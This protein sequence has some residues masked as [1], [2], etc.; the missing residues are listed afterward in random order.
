M[1]RGPK[2]EA[3]VFEFSLLVRLPTN[4]FMVFN[5]TICCPGWALVKCDAVERLGGTADS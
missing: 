3:K 1:R 2:L 5:S 4:L